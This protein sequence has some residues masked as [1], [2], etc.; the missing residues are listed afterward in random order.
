AIEWGIDPRRIGVLGYSAGGHLASLLSTR[1]D[2][3]HDPA[4]D[5][6]ASVPARPDLVALA[7]PL[8]SFVDGYAP[9]AFLGSGESFFGRDDG[10]EAS[11]RNFS[12]ELHVG[13]DHPPVF[14]WTTDD[15]AL[16]PSSHPKRFVEACRRVNVPVTFE[17]YPHGPHGLGLAIGSPGDV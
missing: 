6:A 2:L 9:G 5:L 12:N 17:L 14:V 13:A 7:Y 4:D 15:D 8:V 10:D 11:R 1:P 16:V 3:F